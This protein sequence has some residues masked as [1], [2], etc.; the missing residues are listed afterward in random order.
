MTI[1]AR[2]RRASRGKARNPAT[3]SVACPNVIIRVFG[4]PAGRAT[5]DGTFLALMRF[6]N[7]TFRSI[8]GV[9]IRAIDVPYR[10]YTQRIRG[11]R[12]QDADTDVTTCEACIS[13]CSTNIQIRSYPN[14]AIAL[15][16]TLSAVKPYSRITTSPGADAP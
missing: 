15:L 10:R 1:I 7:S 8:E 5:E 2:W 9:R 3:F 13:I 14:D 4:F 16:H 12:A 11:V 6:L